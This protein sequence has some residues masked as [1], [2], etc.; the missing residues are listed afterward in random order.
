MVTFQQETVGTEPRVRRVAMVPRFASVRRTLT[1][2]LNLT[3][4]YLKDYRTSRI[5]PARAGSPDQDSLSSKATC[6]PRPLLP[7][8][9]QSSLA[10][11]TRKSPDKPVT[12]AG[13]T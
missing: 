10:A 9:L 6:L 7:I 5:T 2:D 11:R 3:F 8:Q 1:W 12:P 13:T 4:I